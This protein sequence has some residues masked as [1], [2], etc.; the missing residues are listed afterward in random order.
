MSP[1]SSITR[2]TDGNQGEF[3]TCRTFTP[4]TILFPFCAAPPQTAN[5]LHK[6]LTV[7]SISVEGQ[8]VPG[9]YAAWILARGSLNQRTSTLHMDFKKV[10]TEP[11]DSQPSQQP[12]K[13]RFTPLEAESPLTRNHRAHV[14][15][16]TG[17][18]V[19]NVAP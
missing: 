16:V 15:D 19:L 5:M 10:G 9:L 3:R 13:L 18:P 2:Y 4:S 14:C 7:Y 8:A 1:S 12:W 6:P 11:A 17:R